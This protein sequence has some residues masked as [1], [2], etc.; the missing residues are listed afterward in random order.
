MHIYHVLTNA[1]SAQMIHINLNMAFYTHVEHSPTKTIYIKYYMEKQTSTRTTH[2]HAC[3][4]AH[5]QTQIHGFSKRNK[6][7]LGSTHS[8]DESGVIWISSVLGTEDIA[9][10]C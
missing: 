10:T 4:H 1:L 5:Y 3:T 8:G 7:S 2:T 6:K 9:H